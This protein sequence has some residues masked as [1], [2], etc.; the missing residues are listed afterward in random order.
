MSIS[1]ILEAHH[2]ALDDTQKNEFLREL[3]E[4]CKD[5]N[6]AEANGRSTRGQV[7]A[8]ATAASLDFVFR[9]L[10]RLLTHSLVLTMSLDSLA[11]ADCVS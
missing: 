5:M 10:M 1:A 4:Q 7:R 2:G 9:S 3:E 6:G 11:C 8:T